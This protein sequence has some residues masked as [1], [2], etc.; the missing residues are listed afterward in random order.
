[1]PD[2]LTEEELSHFE[3]LIILPMVLAVLKQ[4]KERVAVLPFKFGR[5]Y[6]DIIESAMKSAESDCKISKI[7]ITKRNLKLYKFQQKDSSTVYQMLCRGSEVHQEYTHAELKRR[8]E[9]LMGTYLRQGISENPS[10]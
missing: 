2:K 1:M 10:L 5:P 9:E 3:N 6:Q 4:D 8:T 7:Y